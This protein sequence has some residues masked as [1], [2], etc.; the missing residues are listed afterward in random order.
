MSNV[1]IKR[2]GRFTWADYQSWSDDQRWEI[3]SG[4]AYLMS[5]SPTSRHQKM[6]TELT[7][8][9]AAQFKGKRCQVFVSPMDVVLSE[10]DVVQ[11]DLL[12][13]CDPNRIKRTHIEG[14]P[15]LVVEVL[16]PTSGLRDR[17]LKLTLYARS[18]VKEYWIVTPW[19]SLVEVLRL[20]GG[21]YVVHEVFGKEQ[22]L[23]S[24]TFPELRVTLAD[25]FDF[26][27]EPGEEPPVVREPPGKAYR[28][29]KAT[30]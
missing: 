13:V 20:E 22:T 1:A 15:A 6:V 4:E 27:L 3:I 18:G 14:A 23:V 19:P 21:R 2:E 7:R 26:P 9:M 5:P 25:V 10:E 24:P 8:Q 17:L 12:V 16:S 28:A 11:P 30:P 29:E